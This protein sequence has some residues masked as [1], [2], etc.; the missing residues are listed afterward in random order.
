MIGN[1][2]F[3]TYDNTHIAQTRLCNVDRRIVVVIKNLM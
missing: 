1:V 3:R 2:E